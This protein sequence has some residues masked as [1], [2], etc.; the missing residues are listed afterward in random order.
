MT[1]SDKSKEI[2]VFTTFDSLSVLG[3][4]AFTLVLIGSIVSHALVDQR[5]PQAQK[6]TRQLASQIAIGG[7]NSPMIADA[8][9]ESSPSRTLASFQKL[10]IRPVGRIGMDPW[11]SPYYYRLFV[12]QN[13]QLKVLVLSTGPDRRLSSPAEYFSPDSMG[14]IADVRILGDDIATF[15]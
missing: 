8:I 1:S 9:N 14:E 11:G 3:V 7:L 12:A 5:V 10:D 4:L 2:Q 15:R 13:E 6:R